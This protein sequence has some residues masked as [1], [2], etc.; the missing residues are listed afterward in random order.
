MTDFLLKKEIQFIEF[1]FIYIYLKIFI[2]MEAIS[3]IIW[4]FH[5]S[6]KIHL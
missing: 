6:K 3:Y 4:I 2:Q 1:F 5:P